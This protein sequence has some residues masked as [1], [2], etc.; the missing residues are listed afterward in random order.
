MDKETLVK[1][2][3]KSS[4]NKNDDGVKKSIETFLYNTAAEKIKNLKIETAKSFF[5]KK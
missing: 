1:N 3:I 4:K 5:Q 2:I